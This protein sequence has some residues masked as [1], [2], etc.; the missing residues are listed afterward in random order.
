MLVSLK[1]LKEKL[2]VCLCVY[3]LLVTQV[4][5]GCCSS[6][7]AVRIELPSRLVRPPGAAALN[8]KAQQLL[9]V[10]RRP[11]K[12]VLT[13]KAE[14]LWS[15]TEL[16]NTNA[17]MLPWCSSI[18]FTTEIW[19]HSASRANLTKSDLRCLSVGALLMAK[20]GN[21]NDCGLYQH[22]VFKCTD[23]LLDTFGEA[24]SFY[25]SPGWFLPFLL[26]P[27][28]T[29]AVSLKQNAAMFW[30]SNEDTDL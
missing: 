10:R 24:G 6:I 29:A 2:W 5:S 21:G 13:D 7:S 11:D 3:V 23:V 20:I 12:L 15:T 8:G 26:C 9:A 1:Q 18:M 30:S 27:P 22:G 28:Q 25:R 19:L 16:R 4:W 17:N 14:Q